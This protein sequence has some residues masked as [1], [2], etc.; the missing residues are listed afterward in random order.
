[1]KVIGKCMSNNCIK[2]AGVLSHKVVSMDCSPPGSSVHG[3]PQARIQEWF[4][5][6]FS[7]GSSRP[8]DQTCVSC[9]GRQVLYHWA[10]GETLYKDDSLFFSSGWR[11]ST[12]EIFWS[13]LPD[14]SRE[15][16]AWHQ[17][18]VTLAEAGAWRDSEPAPGDRRSA[19]RGPHA[20]PLPCSLSHPRALVQ[21]SCA[22]VSRKYTDLCHSSL[23]L[24][25]PL[26]H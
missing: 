8:R 26:E 24:C 21:T 14:D 11:S 10:T 6:S 5:I 15:K 25:H 4:A 7:R 3:I 2:I 17:V 20:S 23:C 1:M 16:A 12:K 22:V 19:C 18:S 13:R 9:I